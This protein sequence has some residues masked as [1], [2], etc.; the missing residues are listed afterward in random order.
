MTLLTEGRYLVVSGHDGF[1]VI[2]TSQ[3]KELF[4]RKVER[5]NA[6]PVQGGRCLLYQAPSQDFGRPLHFFC[7]RVSDGRVASK[8]SRQDS[9]ETLMPGEDDGVVY[10]VKYG[11]LSR[12]LFRWPDQR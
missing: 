1:V 10:A 9:Y 2:E 12:L 7:V 4:R 5:G 6:V 11:T 8:F 3:G